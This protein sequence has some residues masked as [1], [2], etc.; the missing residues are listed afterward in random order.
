MK[1]VHIITGLGQGG[2]EGALHRLVQFS[3][4]PTEHAIISLMND[5]IHGEALRAL[6]CT[7]HALN[8]RRGT[9]T[10]PAFFKLRKLIKMA[11]PNVVQTWMYHSDLVGG[12]AARTLGLPVVWGIRRTDDSLLDLGISTW[13]IAKA[14]VLLGDIPQFIVSCSNRAIQNHRKFGY[15]NRFIY[16]P[17][18]FYA[19]ELEQPA[20]PEGFPEIRPGQLVFGHVA[21]LYPHKGHT[22]FLRAFRK[23]HEQNPDMLAVMVGSHI[24]PDDAKFGHILQLYG[25][26]GVICLGSRKD[27][28]ALMRAFD[29]F[30][31]SSLGEGFPN[32]VAEAMI[33]GT[34]CIVTDVGDAADIVGDTG[35]V[36][37]KKDPLLLAQAMMEA[38]QASPEELQRRGLAA[39]QRIIERYSMQNMVQAFYSVWQQAIDKA[40][41]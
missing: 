17:N 14:C 21:R 28:P 20:N 33:Q 25:D 2:A 8:M 39:R 4:N 37:S 9:F 38:A 29:F 3:P 19:H 1:I 18:G 35:W 15:P 27:V 24:L 34:P 32:V 41:V 13:L 7:V 30:V 22:L 23:I 11:N 31:L 16:I 12:L 26:A 5:G 40:T 6:G 36:I 10:L